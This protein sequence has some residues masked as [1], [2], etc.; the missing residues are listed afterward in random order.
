[1]SHLTSCAE[2]IPIPGL[3]CPH[4]CVSWIHM[5][6]TPA[7]PSIT[8]ISEHRVKGGEH[9]T[10]SALPVRHILHPKPY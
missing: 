2:S 7:R 1:M 9:S 8:S 10:T 6:L 3:S 5:P 4:F